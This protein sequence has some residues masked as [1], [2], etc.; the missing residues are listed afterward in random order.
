[1]SKKEEYHPIGRRTHEN[2]KIY[3]KCE[4]KEGI[5]KW[6]DLEKEK[7]VVG[8][9]FKKNIGIP[10]FVLPDEKPEQL[11]WIRKIFNEDDQRKMWLIERNKAIELFEKYQ[12]IEEYK[13]KTFILVRLSSISSPEIHVASIDI[14]LKPS[15]KIYYKPLPENEKEFYV[16]IDK[17]K[18]IEKTLTELINKIKEIYY[19]DKYVF[20][21]IDETVNPIIIDDFR[22]IYETYMGRALPE[23]KKLSKEEKE[24]KIKEIFNEDDQEKLWLITKEDA[25]KLFQKYRQ[26]I[27]YKDKTFILVRIANLENKPTFQGTHIATMD[28]NAQ[29]SSQTDSIEIFYNPKLYFTR[30]PT[31]FRISMYLDPEEIM[32]NI[33]DT[34]TLTELI[35]NAKQVLINYYA[36]RKNI[37]RKEAEKQ[38]IIFDINEPF[39]NDFMEMKRKYMK[40]EK[41]IFKTEKKK[42]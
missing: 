11:K 8:N 18:I 2:G 32:A 24:K 23:K 7:Y 27:E 39:T 38:F 42:L 10:A 3:I 16:T 21:D 29:F 30:S 40:N 34:K 17:K 12:K 9:P 5:H 25:E 13:D 36:K 1:M 41:K 35:E 28:I 31:K 19:E 14:S 33:I 15:F 6:Y 37:T 22:K 20:L 26:L 4:N